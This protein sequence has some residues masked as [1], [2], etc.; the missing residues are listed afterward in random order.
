MLLAPPTEGHRP[1]IQSKNVNIG[2][3]WACLFA[4]RAKQANDFAAE[5]G[6]EE[7][8][9]CC[10]CEFAHGGDQRLIYPAHVDPIHGTADADKTKVSDAFSQLSRE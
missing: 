4:A 8:T 6:F 2:N 3:R 1:S 7:G 10:L 5:L 9:A